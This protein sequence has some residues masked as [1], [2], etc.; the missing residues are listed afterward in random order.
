[1]SGGQCGLE[2]QGS[3]PCRDTL[4]YDQPTPSGN[5]P[6][7]SGGQLHADDT[8]KALYPNIPKCTSDFLGT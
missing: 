6:G 7:Q 3:P 2:M 4:P 8:V 5:K 1:M